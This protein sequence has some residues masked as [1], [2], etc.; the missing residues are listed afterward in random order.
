MLF[1]LI[2]VAAATNGLRIQFLFL[3]L[4]P[5]L[6]THGYCPEEEKLILQVWLC[7]DQIQSDLGQVLE[8]DVFFASRS[9]TK[10]DMWS[11]LHKAALWP[12]S[13]AITT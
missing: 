6:C 11:E 2:V 12:N 5:Y 7:T 4:I 1:Q 8:W 13:F 9:T 10:L 3:Y